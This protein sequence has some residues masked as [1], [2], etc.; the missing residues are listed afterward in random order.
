M[1]KHALYYPHIGLHNASLTK[2]LALYFDRVYRIVPDNVI[3][4]DNEELQPLL[5]E[6]TVGSKIDPAP[7]S[8]SASDEFLSKLGE[9]DA[10]A[11]DGDPDGE[12]KLSRLHVEKTDERVRRLFEESGFQSH[13]DWMAIPTEI[14]SNYML[15][16]ATIIAKKNNLSLITSDWGAWTGT[17]Y[18]NMDGQIDGSLS[19][20][21]MSEYVDDPFGLFCLVVSGITPINISEIPS[22]KILDFRR[23]RADE[24]AN[25]RKCLNDL[26][27]ELKVIDSN[28]IKLD[29]IRDKV[30]SLDK[31]KTNYQESADIIKVKGWTGTKMIGFPAIVELMKAMDIPFASM[32]PLNTTAL[33]LT[34][35]ALGVLC[36]IKS[37]AQDIKKLNRENPSS[38][39]IEMNRSFKDYTNQRGGGDINYHAWN[40]MEEFIND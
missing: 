15:Y 19:P 34:G 28:E 27:E 35:I 40:C 4:D 10:A 3:P 30:K 16:L 24:I 26:R 38:F 14:A 33:E 31:A 37:N 7:Y 22:S 39:L 2:A 9:W 18:F 23:K 25:F 32:I 36:T 5:E 1:Q 13:N 11:L 8:V 21:L 6:G 12:Q 29:T 17:S 20:D